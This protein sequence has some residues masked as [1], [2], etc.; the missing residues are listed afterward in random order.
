MEMKFKVGDNVL[1]RKDIGELDEHDN[2]IY[3]GKQG[4]NEEMVALAGHIATITS[5]NESAKYY[6]IDLDGGDWYWEENHFE[7][8]KPIPLNASSADILDLDTN[9]PHHKIT[10]YVNGFKYDMC[11]N[12][13]EFTKD[14]GWL[15]TDNEGRPFTIP[16]DWVDSIVRIS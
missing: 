11:V 6:K 5:V 10:Y 9:K 15:V 2:Y 13:A 16:N 14:D 12:I 1:I 7:E 4:L 8:I 3:E